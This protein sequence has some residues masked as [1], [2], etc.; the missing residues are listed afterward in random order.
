MNFS[1]RY[2]V[3]FTL[4][5][6]LCIVALSPAF[7]ADQRAPAAAS[8]RTSAPP[9]SSSVLPAEFGGWQ[10]KGELAKSNDPATADAA[11]APVL[12]EY[13][14][15][16]LEKA[17]YTRDDGRNLVIKAAVFSDT[18]GAYG[19]FTYYQSPEM[20][21]ETIGGQGASLGKRVLF[22]QGNGLVDAGFD[23]WGGSAAGTL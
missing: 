19:A 18:S 13:G 1:R 16:H 2:P 4:F 3:V 6:Y 8:A 7:A 22:Y 5:F 17:S 20:A 14:F 12:K 23:R 11:D 15:Q 10:L 9:S 21:A